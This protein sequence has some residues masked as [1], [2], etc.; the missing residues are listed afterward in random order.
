MTG[1][2][3]CI[4]LHCMPIGENMK[5]TCVNVV[6]HD[7]VDIYISPLVSGHVIFFVTCVYNIVCVKAR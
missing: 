4:V 3:I 6:S 2:D 1:G 7:A 5:H